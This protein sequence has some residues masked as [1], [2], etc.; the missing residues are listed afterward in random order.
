MCFFFAKFVHTNNEFGSDSTLILMK[1]VLN[2][3]VFEKGKE[4]TRNLVF[5][6]LCFY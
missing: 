6:P 1:N 3:N 4:K 5:V 2:I